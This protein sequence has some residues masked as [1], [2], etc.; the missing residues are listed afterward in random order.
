MVKKSISLKH[1]FSY[2]LLFCLLLDL[3]NS[4][5]SQD[6]WKNVYFEFFLLIYFILIIIWILIIFLKY[7]MS[8]E[9]YINNQKQ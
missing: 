9:A 1:L 5:F 8:I 4:Y 3:S 7:D 2:L 6:K